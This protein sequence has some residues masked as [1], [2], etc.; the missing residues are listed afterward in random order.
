MNTPLSERLRKQLGGP[1]DG[2]LL[3][4][5]LGNALL[6]EDDASGAVDAFRAAL[7]FKPDYSAAWKL[8]AAAQLKAGDASAAQASYERGIEVAHAAGDIQAAKEMQ[9]FLRRLRKSD[10][11]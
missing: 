11:A 7:E 6:A 9:V 8:L 10:P 4:F 3:R 2:A 1:R 5:S